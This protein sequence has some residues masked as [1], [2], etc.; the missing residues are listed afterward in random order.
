LGLILWIILF[1]E[2]FLN[3][4]NMGSIKFFK[5]RSWGKMCFHQSLSL[6]FEISHKNL[7]LLSMFALTH[8]YNM[9]FPIHLQLP[10][11]SIEKKMTFTPMKLSLLHIFLIHLLYLHIHGKKSLTLVT[12]IYL[13]HMWLLLAQM[14]VSLHLHK[15]NSKE[16]FEL[17]QTFSIWSLI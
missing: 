3:I 11:S 2:L 6:N 7:Q 15:E 12:W 1:F 17:L 8:T 16:D 10:H 5:M 14:Y 9:N 4:P 13:T